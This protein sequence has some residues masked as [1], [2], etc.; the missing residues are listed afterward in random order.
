MIKLEQIALIIY[1][2]ASTAGVLIIKNFLNT[3]R[4]DNAYEFIYQLINVNLI[5]GVLLYVAGFLTW[6]YVLS[7]MDLNI[8]YPVAIT[9]SFLA[10]V[11]L[12]SLVLH[13]KITSNIIIGTAICLIGIII[14]LR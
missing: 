1:V 8:A 7:K 9:L 11:L 10:I 4:Y 12:S 5:I 6:L 14:I 13:E 2:C 3:I